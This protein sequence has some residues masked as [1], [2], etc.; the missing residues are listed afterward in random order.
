MSRIAQWD[1]YSVLETAKFEG[2]RNGRANEKIE[3]ARN[4]KKEGF[5]TAMII[6]MTGLSPAE[7]ERLN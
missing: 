3:I 7:I 2:E 5:D 6:K 1:N 4:M